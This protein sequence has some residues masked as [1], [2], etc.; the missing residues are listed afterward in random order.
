MLDSFGFKT[1]NMEVPFRGSEDFGIYSNYAPS[2]FF[3]V[4]NGEEYTPLHNDN[5]EFPDDLLE[6]RINLWT[7]IGKG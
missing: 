3:H 5:Y 1:R 7:T 4:G 6:L 2:M